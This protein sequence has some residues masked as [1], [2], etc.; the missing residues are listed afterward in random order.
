MASLLSSGKTPAGWSCGRI[1][2]SPLSLSLPRNQFPSDSPASRQSTKRMWRGICFAEKKEDGGDKDENSEKKPTEDENQSEK[3]NEPKGDLKWEASNGGPKAP[4][5][6]QNSTGVLSKESVDIMRNQIFGFDTFF[7]TGQEPYGGGVLF[8]GNLRGD[9]AKTHAKLMQRLKEKFGDQFS[10]FLLKESD[11]DRPVAVIIPTAD[12][13]PSSGA[14]P[15]W[16]AATAFGLTTIF[17]VLQVNTEIE[18]ENLPS[19]E[20]LSKIFSD[21]W[22]G[23]LVVAAVLAA[24]EL[25]HLAAAK[26]AGIRLSV[27]YFIPSW[28]LGTFGAITRIKDVVP[29]RGVLA[30]VAAAG[31]L[32]G[33]GVALVILLGSLLMSSGVGGM[34]VESSLFHDSLLVGGLGKAILGDRLVEGGSLSIS[35]FVIPAW[36]ALLVNAINSIPVGELDGGRIA[37]ALWG[38]KAASRWTGASLFLL[39]GSAFF[40]DVAFYWVILLVLLQRGPVLPQADELTPPSQNQVFLGVGTLVL[41]FLVCC[42]QPFPFS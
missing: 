15:E 11:D 31:P 37:H 36:F 10:L 7:V 30:D 25:G 3:T 1:R 28:Q 12:V 18:L 38:R 22:P 40:D 41:G 19:P 8:K 13:I 39:A 17:T 20:Y 27:P 14:V 33:S 16:V 35:P 34:A 23:A 29:T 5:F 24:H 9:S 6:F 4:S 32:A 2:G 21:A 42:P 26:R